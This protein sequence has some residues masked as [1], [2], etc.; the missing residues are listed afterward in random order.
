MDQAMISQNISRMIETKMIPGASW[1]FHSETNCTRHYAGKMGVYPSFSERQINEG[2]FYDLASLTKVI[3]TTT[4]I[5]QLIDERKLEFK[6]SVAEVLPAFSGIKVTIQDLLLH[7]SGLPADFPKKESITSSALYH[8]FTRCH[9]AD[10]SYPTVYSDLGFLLLG[11]IIK[12]IDRCS[13]EKSFRLNIFEP[14]GMLD[15]GYHIA[16]PW[17]A[18]PTEETAARGTIQGVVH[19]SKAFKLK[20]AVGSAGLFSTLTDIDRFVT[21][22]LVNDSRLFSQL[23]FD[24]VRSTDVRGRTYGWEQK[25]GKNGT[26]LFHTGFTGT[27][28]GLDLEERTGFV[29]LTNRIHPSRKDNGFIEARAALYTNYF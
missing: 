1:S 17:Q 28:I 18:I 23:L 11:E 19:D 24:K 9:L 29:L 13:L 4:R 21:A 8:Y 22:Y 2:L 16:E 7:K 14:L 3:G 12:T 15:T 10:E 25:Q 5:L 20:E 27:S 26:Y 6:T